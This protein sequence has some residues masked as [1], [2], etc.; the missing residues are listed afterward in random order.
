[1]YGEVLD[2]NLL[3]STQDVRLGK[4]FTSQQ[5]NDPKHTAGTSLNVL[6]F[7]SQSPDFNPIEHL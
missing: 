2:E 4:R 7:P 6:E 1:M 5:Y 3:Q